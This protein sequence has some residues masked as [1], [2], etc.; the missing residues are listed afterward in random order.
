MAT[1]KWNESG[2]AAVSGEWRVAKAEEERKWKT[3]GRRT[4]T[5]LK[6]CTKAFLFAYGQKAPEIELKVA[7]FCSSLPPSYIF[8]SSSFLVQCLCLLWAYLGRKHSDLLA[9]WLSHWQKVL[10]CEDSQAPG[11]RHPGPV[12]PAVTN[13][14][15]SGSPGESGADLEHNEA[16]PLFDFR[17][18]NAIST[19]P[20]SLSLLCCCCCRYDTSFCDQ[21]VF[22]STCLALQFVS[23]T[24]LA[25]APAPAPPVPP[26]R[27]CWQ[28]LPACHSSAWTR[29]SS[30]LAADK[31]EWQ[32]RR[33]R[34]QRRNNQ[35]WK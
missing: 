8:C 12:P 31:D 5:Q 34:N 16:L 14:P 11:S 1:K 19:W 30:F 3:T 10:S 17:D 33:S 35:K 21:Y 29:P 32:V 9:C 6:T 25:L 28:Q 7:I 22:E 20:H 2:A 13:E 27:N 15:G 24:A 18:A 26:D 4:L 23:I